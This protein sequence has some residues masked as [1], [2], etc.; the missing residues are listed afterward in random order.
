M[1]DLHIQPYKRFQSTRTRLLI[2]AGAVALFLLVYFLPEPRPVHTSSGDVL[3]THTGKAC[4]G[5]L[6]VAVVLWLTEALPFAMTSVLLLIIMPFFKITEGMSMLKNGQVVSVEGFRQGFY[7][8]IELSFGNRILFFFL[9]VFLLSAGF[10]QSGLGKRLVLWIL[11]ASGSSPAR[12]IMGVLLGGTLISMWVTDMAAA[13]IMAALGM[14]ILRRFNIRPLESNFGRALMIACCWGSLFGGIAT[15]AGCGPNPIAIAFLKDMAGYSLTFSG[16]MTLGLPASLILVPLG[17]VVLTR[18]FP[19]E[20][21]KLDAK[22]ADF[23]KELKDLGPLSRVEWRTI[24]IFGLVILLWI[25]SGAIKELTGGRV[26][27]PMEWVALFGGLILMFPGIEVM[28]MEQAEKSIPWNA[29]IL[30]MASMGLGLMMYETG[31]ARWMAWVLMGGL[32]DVNPVLRIAL[33]VTALLIIKVFLASNTVTG[34]IIIPLLI[35][36]A[37]DLNINPWMLVAPAAFS[38]SLGLILITQTP[39]NVI[40]YS[41]GF[42]TVRE[43]LKSGLVMSIVIIIVL[44][45]VIAL[46][47]PLTGTYKF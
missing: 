26:D 34:I 16:W 31:A 1:S 27:L 43:F 20:I 12:V 35:S 32:G 21:K 6:L 25:S 38:A 9:G 36:L 22:G 30:V 10:S 23:K 5:I 46:I 13:A 42:F 3:L 17:W 44:T 7:E 11:R 47:G 33:V 41:A 37:Q 24:I 15:P 40:P 39:T 29:I 45:A 14:E 18:L 28:T 19:F 8:L 4:I 2:I